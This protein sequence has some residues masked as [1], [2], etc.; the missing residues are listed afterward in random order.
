MKSMNQSEVDA[1]TEGIDGWFCSATYPIFECVHHGVLV[2]T[3]YNVGHG[4]RKNAR[5]LWCPLCFS[6][7]SE[8]WR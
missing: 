2:D 3:V 8:L 6:A 1:R 5:C 7:S 4:G